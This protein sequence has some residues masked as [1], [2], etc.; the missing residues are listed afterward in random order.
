MLMAINARQK[1]GKRNL[2]MLKM[3]ILFTALVGFSFAVITPTPAYAALCV[4]HKHTGT[5]RGPS[6]KIAK[7]AARQKWRYEVRKHKH[8]AQ[9]IKNI[10]W[11]NSVGQSSSCSRKFR[12]YKCKVQAYPCKSKYMGSRKVQIPPVL[13]SRWCQKSYRDSRYAKLIGK[14]AGDWVC[15]MKNGSHRPI[16][17]KGVCTD[18]WGIPN[19][20]RARADDWNDPKSWKCYVRK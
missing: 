17:V 3:T 18:Y 5:G 1:A 4:K 8:M 20:L 7:Y 14:T 11:G 16:S 13:F 10:L 2:S 19:V 6:E 15:I 9:N 12:I